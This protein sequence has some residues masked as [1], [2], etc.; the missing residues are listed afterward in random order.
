MSVE[1]NRS[2]ERTREPFNPNPVVAIIRADQEEQIFRRVAHP[3]SAG[4]VHGAPPAVAGAGQAP[5]QV[6]PALCDVCNEGSGPLATG[7]G[8]HRQI[9][10]ASAPAHYISLQFAHM[11]NFA[12]SA[13]QQSDVPR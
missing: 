4:Q 8:R 9:D 3:A 7:G 11:A 1:V 6:H 13:S 2:D 10:A 5:G 12:I